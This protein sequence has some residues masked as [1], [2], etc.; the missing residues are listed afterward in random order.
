[1][2]ESGFRI[3]IRKNQWIITKDAT[4]Q[5]HL[6]SSNNSELITVVK[7]VSGAEQVIP[8]MVI[9]SGQLIMERWVTR[10]QF[11][12]NCFLAMSESGYLNN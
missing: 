3:G 1:M 11:K 7:A 10:T 9:L 6:T 12:D 2:D 5:S 8:P 4:Q